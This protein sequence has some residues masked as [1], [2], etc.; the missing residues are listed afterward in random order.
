MFERL[1]AR[2]TRGIGMD[3]LI[4]L[5]LKGGGAGASFALNLLISRTMGAEGVGAYQIALATTTLLA[6]AANIGLDTVVLRSV[7]V[8][9]RRGDE[10]AAHAAIRRAL[11]VV[12]LLGLAIGGAMLLLAWPMTH[13]LMERPELFWPVAIM[14]AAVPV[15]ALVRTISA[16]IRATGSVLLSQS[17]D[18]VSYTGMT[19]L[20]LGGLWVG[21]GSVPVLAPEVVYAA[22]CLIVMLFGLTRI[23]KLTRHWPVG[24]QTLSL[25]SGLRIMVIYLAAFFCDWIAVVTLGTWH[26]PAEAG[27]YRVAMQFGLLFTLVRNSFDQM[28]GSHIA[29]RFADGNYRGMLAIAR[30]TGM[31][32]GALCLPLLG[33]ILLAPEWLLGLFGPGFVRGSSALLILA[34]GQF[35]AVTVGPIGT[36]LDMA[37]REHIAMRIEIGVTIVTI[38]LFLVLI[39][40]YDLTG[41]AMAIT[42]AIIGRAVA[43]LIANRAF[44]RTMERRSA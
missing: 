41:A 37:H 9:L 5:A 12:T 25:K 26:G 44:I 34:I 7:A 17:L 27:I 24:A 42:L 35:I 28:V 13:L 8:A 22:A 40:L 14:A 38:G 2:F 36:V 31:I 43:L 32:G 33:L 19:V 16:S 30:K 18:G 4:G 23:R 29:A 39:P 3:L 11:R 21:L 6:V 20:V 10:G 15:I 1:K